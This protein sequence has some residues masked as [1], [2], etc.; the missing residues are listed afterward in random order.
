MLI[1][2]SGLPWEQKQQCH[3]NIKFYLTRAFEAV[4]W[5]IYVNC[6]ITMKDYHAQCLWRLL[7]TYHRCIEVFLTLLLEFVEISMAFTL[8]VHAVVCSK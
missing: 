5:K 1:S 7:G 6:R 8:T 2:C 4:R 3:S